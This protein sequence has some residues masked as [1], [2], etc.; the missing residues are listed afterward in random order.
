MTSEGSPVA[1]I[2]RNCTNASTGSSVTQ[3]SDA[4]CSTYLSTCFFNKNVGCTDGGC[5]T[6]FGTNAVCSAITKAQILVNGINTP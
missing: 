5:S 3:N 6:Y 4:T 1:C 2:D